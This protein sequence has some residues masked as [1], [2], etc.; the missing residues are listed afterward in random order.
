MLTWQNPVAFFA[1]ALGDHIINLPALRAIS[2][3][4]PNQ[5][6]LVTRDCAAS[7]LF[8]ELPLR[9][10]VRIAAPVADKGRWFDADS[11]A[12]NL[13]QVDCFLS[14]NPWHSEVIVVGLPIFSFPGNGLIKI[15][16]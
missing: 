11:L 9:R 7:V 12:A 5:L 4:M 2:S 10:L 3:L 14:L 6:T 15:L 13:G 1:N 16:Q 8:E